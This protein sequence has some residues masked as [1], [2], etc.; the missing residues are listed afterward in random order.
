MR[1]FFFLTILFCQFSFGQQDATVAYGQR[2]IYENK[3]AEAIAYFTKHLLQPKNS[4]QE[5]ELLLGLAEVYKLKLNY[6][7]ANSYYVKAYE[8]LKKSKSKRGK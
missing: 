6:N 3:D 1:Y 2:L 7:K 8:K 4:N 5:I